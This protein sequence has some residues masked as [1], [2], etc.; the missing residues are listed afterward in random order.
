[1]RFRARSGDRENAIT[2]VAGNAF[3]EAATFDGPLRAGFDVIGSYRTAE[4][5]LTR[6][7]GRLIGKP[8][9]ASS[10][11]GRN[12]NTAANDCVAAVLS[13]CQLGVSRHAVAI[14]KLAAVEAFPSSFLG[15]M[16]E[17]P[18]SVEA[19]RGNRS[20][21][22]FE[23]LTA[24]GTFNNL[25][26]YL[27]PGRE[28]AT[29]LTDVTNHDDRAALVCALTALAVAGGDFTAVGDKNGWIVLPPH[30]FVQAWAW[31]ELVANACEEQPGCLYRTPLE[32]RADERTSDTDQG[33]NRGE[34]G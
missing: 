21:V 1:M 15:V 30:C 22:Y 14:H 23:R 29:P 20:D 10:P 24:V 28:I 25:L 6:R 18:A 12:L 8:G 9:Q 2:A 27:L 17:D 5:M 33:G 26:A 4:R 7:L 11:V 32:I 3:L 19:R 13:N 34:R 16:L 31:K